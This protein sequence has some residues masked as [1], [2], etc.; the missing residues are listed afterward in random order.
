MF[1]G[2]SKSGPSALEQMRGYVGCGVVNSGAGL[3]TRVVSETEKC[4]FGACPPAC[5]SIYGKENRW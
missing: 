4:S 2:K 1:P 3:S 5:P